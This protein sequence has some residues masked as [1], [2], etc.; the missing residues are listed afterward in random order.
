M[1]LQ[2]ILCSR[3]AF[4]RGEG[5]R[6]ALFFGPFSSSFGTQARGG[7]GA[8]QAR[9]YRVRLRAGVHGRDVIVAYVYCDFIACWALA[10]S[11]LS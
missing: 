2:Q 4:C 3:P 5:K 9:D 11:H 7:G 10:V 8:T 6:K 1:G